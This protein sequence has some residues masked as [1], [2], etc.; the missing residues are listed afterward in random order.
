MQGA[1]AL[2]GLNV[3]VVDLLCNARSYQASTYSSD[4]FHPNDTGYAYIADEAIKAINAGS[5]AAAGGQL[6]ADDPRPSVMTDV[7]HRGTEITETHGERLWQRTD[8]PLRRGHPE[9]CQIR[10]PC[11]LRVS[12]SLWLTSDL[13]AFLHAQFRRGAW[14]CPRRRWRC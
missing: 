9:R 2:V 11:V 3:T 13:P 7:N 1:N 4:G 6:P 8:A 12:V 14:R 10:S 5:R